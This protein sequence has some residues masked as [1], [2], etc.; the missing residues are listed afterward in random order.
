[1]TWR[2]R[3]DATHKPVMQAL[4]ACGW[5]VVDTSRLKRF[6][7]LIAVKGGRVE[8]IEIKDGSKPPSARK[9]TPDEADLHSALKQAGVEVR[10]IESVEQAIKLGS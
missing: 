7:D 6:V 5:L 3:V 1:M 10:I 4:R 8:W 2:A 9:L